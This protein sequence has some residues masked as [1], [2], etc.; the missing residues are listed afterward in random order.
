M[1]KYLIFSVFYT[2]HEQI[3]FSQREVY[4][5]FLWKPFLIL[6]YLQKVPSEVMQASKDLN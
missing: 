4:K 1:S 2:D 6:P 5:Y 3:F